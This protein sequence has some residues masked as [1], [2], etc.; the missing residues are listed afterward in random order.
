MRINLQRDRGEDARDL[1]RK[2]ADLEK[3][4]AN[5]AREMERK[6]KLKAAMVDKLLLG[7]ITPFPQSVAR[8]RLPEK[9]KVPQIQS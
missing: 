2:V 7:T 3:K 5:M 1:G 9:F 6:D 4:C 8:Y